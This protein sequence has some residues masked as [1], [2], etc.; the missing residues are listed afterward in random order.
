[1]CAALQNKK[2]EREDEDSDEDAIGG[3]FKLK[4]MNASESKGILHDRDCSL[5][6]ITTP[7]RDWS[8]PEVLQSIWDCFVT[9]KWKDSEDAEMLL[10]DDDTSMNLSCSMPKCAFLSGRFPVECREAKVMITANQKKR[11]IL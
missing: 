4:P 11:L 5:E 6:V 7:L 2:E 9:G 1:M 8:Q 10:Q 3:I